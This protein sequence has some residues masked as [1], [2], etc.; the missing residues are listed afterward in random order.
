M[1]SFIT[2]NLSLLLLSYWRVY[3]NSSWVDVSNLLTDVSITTSEQHYR[4]DFV[5]ATN[6]FRIYMT[7]PRRDCY[8]SGRLCVKNMYMYYYN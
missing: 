2:A 7:N 1:K 3:L 6:K 4:F 5:N 8:N